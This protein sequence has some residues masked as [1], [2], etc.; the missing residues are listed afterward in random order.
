MGSSSSSSWWAAGEDRV[1]ARLVVVFEEGG[2]S[3]VVAMEAMEAGTGL[4][5]GVL[6]LA[7]PFDKR[8]FR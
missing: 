6:P 3:G 1:V 2:G 7:P 4:A 5:T 8:C